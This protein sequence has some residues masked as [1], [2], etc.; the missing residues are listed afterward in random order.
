MKRFLKFIFRIFL[1]L[2]IAFVIFFFWASSSTLD[3][4]EYAKLIEVDNHIVPENDSIFSI[5]TYN[6]GY[7]SGM[8]NN[9]AVESPKKLF[10][11]NLDKVISEVKK[12]NPDIMAF[13]E[14]DFDASRS[15]NVN[16][17]EEISK[18]GFN[19]IAQTIN[20]DERYLPFPYWPISMH[21]GKVVSGQSIISKYPLKEQQRIVLQ[22]VADAPFHRDAFYL[23]RL[24]Q[25]VKVVLNGKEVVLINIH[26]EA[27]DKQTRVNQFE[28][29]L[30]IFN[31][32]KNDYPTI[33]LGDFNS[34]ARD[35]DAI[36]QK[37][38]TMK[39]IGNAGFDMNNLGNTFDTKDPFE[40]IDYIFY[41]KNTIEYIS[42]KVLNEF[43]QASD[44]LPVEMQFKL[45]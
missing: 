26:L 7:L 5:V 34:R 20:W 9:L 6:I 19:Y 36:I 22:R 1:V 45:K 43:G 31:T 35:K 33:L 18:L 32:Y 42:G 12:V 44:H 8:T 21:Y 13:Q 16:Q 39:A 27:F 17:E 29:V 24:A 11:D 3:K 28:E 2:I 14:I 30:A 37:I 23:E 15:Y 25:V 4:S 38:F 10:N 40:R 41:T